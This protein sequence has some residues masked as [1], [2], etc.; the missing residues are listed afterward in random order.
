MTGSNLAGLPDRGD[1]KAALATSSWT[2]LVTNLQTG[3][4]LVTASLLNI[5]TAS[6]LPLSL[7]LAHN[8]M[9][10]SIDV[11]VGKD[12]M[13]NLH[14]CVSE[15]GQSGDI[16]YM[17]PSGAL[18]VFTYDSQTQTYTNPKGF[19][20]KLTKEVS[21]EYILQGLNH[22]KQVFG[23]DGKLT[24]ISEV[25]GTNPDT[26]NIAY[27]GNGNPITAT[28]SLSGRAITL[29]WDANQKLS[30]INDPMSNTWS[31]TQ[32]AS[33]QLTTI[34]QPEDGSQTP[35]PTRPTTTFSYDGNNLITG[36]DDFLGDSYE[37]GYEASSP[38]KITSWI[39]KF[40][41]KCIIIR[42]RNTNISF[43]FSY[44]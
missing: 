31:F 13:T 40:Y 28:D 10:A 21:G 39:H 32:N 34:T 44:C 18:Y 15:D 11:G 16:T 1:E 30:S 24:T 9:N 6:G 38:Y 17:D 42:C 2:N 27:N 25:C 33:N 22:T 35:P 23:T 8:S 12:W 26:I 3:N 20:G 41:N 43:C 36:H 37:I 14:T 5:P 29:T 19:A 7:Q 4:H